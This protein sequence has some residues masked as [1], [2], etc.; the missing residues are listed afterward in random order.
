MKNKNR[1]EIIIHGRGGQGAKTTAE[2]LVQAAQAAGKYVQAFPQFGPERSGA[3]V[4]TYVRISNDPIRSH[5]PVVDPDCVL[6]LD[7]SILGSILPIENLGKAEPFIVNSKKQKNQLGTEFGLK[8]NVITID[9]SGL[10]MDIIGE[11]RPNSVILGKFAFVTEVV[12]IKDIARAFRQKYLD[13]IGQ[14]KV[15][16]N[17]EAI[18]KAYENH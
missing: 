3:P 10:A 12:K 7:E 15:E 18:I 8:G 6:V 2:L 5:E 13:K 4:S 1:Y 14:E 9:A 16:K 17:I 11:N